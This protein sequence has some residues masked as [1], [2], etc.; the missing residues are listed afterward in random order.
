MAWALIDSAS[1]W[2]LARMSAASARLAGLLLGAERLGGGAGLFDDPGGLGL[3]VGERLL[4][5]A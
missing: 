1:A 2:A 3:G 4:V 5:A